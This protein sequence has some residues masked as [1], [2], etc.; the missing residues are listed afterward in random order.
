MRKTCPHC[1]HALTIRE[2]IQNS[3]SQC[4]SRAR[5][6]HFAQ[7]RAT[8]SSS[9]KSNFDALLCEEL[10]KRNLKCAA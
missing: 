6:R 9:I 3:C 1:N 5:R 10:K 8:T 7:T 2:A 4:R